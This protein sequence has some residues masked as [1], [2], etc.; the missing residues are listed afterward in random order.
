MHLDAHIGLDTHM[1]LP[2]G[3]HQRDGQS[4]AL[5]SAHDLLP[6]SQ[7]RASGQVDSPR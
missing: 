4:L 1:R 6:L 2:I 3:G 7:A 5:L